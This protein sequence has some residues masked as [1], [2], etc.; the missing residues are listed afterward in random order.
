MYCVLCCAGVNQDSSD[1]L[2]ICV[3]TLNQQPRITLFRFNMIRATMRDDG[4]KPH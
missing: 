4:I 3:V 1:T 2:G